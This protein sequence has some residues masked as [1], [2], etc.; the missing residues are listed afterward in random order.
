MIYM[1]RWLKTLNDQGLCLLTGVPCTDEGGFKVYKFK[2]HVKGD[3]GMHNAK[4]NHRS[5]SLHSKMIVQSCIT[6]E[7]E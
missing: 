4:K 1:Y 2:N 7:P 5:K 3:A 6:P